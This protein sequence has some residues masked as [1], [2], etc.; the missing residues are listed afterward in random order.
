MLRPQGG[1]G[2]RGAAF[3]EAVLAEYRPHIDDSELLLEVCRTMDP[4]E[5]LTGTVE[6]EGGCD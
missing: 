5:A 1:L 6:R 3:W 4:V 2:R